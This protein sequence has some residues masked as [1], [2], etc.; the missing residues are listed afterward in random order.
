MG[1]YHSSIWGIIVPHPSDESRFQ[2]I[3]SKSL[4][5]CSEWDDED[6]Q[7]FDVTDRIGSLWRDADDIIRT[8]ISGK[9]IKF[10]MPGEYNGVFSLKIPIP[11]IPPQVESID[12]N[13]DDDDDDDGFFRR[14]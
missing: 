4:K 9:V 12:D 14:I 3:K 13:Y 5:S 1:V 8:D 7:T 11:K 10:T 2:F 6:V